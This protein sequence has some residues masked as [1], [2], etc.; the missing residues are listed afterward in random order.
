MQTR[1]VLVIYATSYGQTRRIAQ[2]VADVLTGAGC[3][4][5]VMNAKE[6]AAAG[7]RPEDYEG[8]VVGGSIIARGL[9]PAIAQFVRAHREALDRLPS[10]FFQVSASAGS[11]KAEGRAAAQQLLDR[12][13][14]QSQWHPDLAV[15]VAGA[16]NYTKYNLFLRWFMKRASRLEGGSTDTSRDHEYTDWAQVEDFARQFLAVLERSRQQAPIG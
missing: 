7:V 3:Q 8:V 13:L 11:A 9:Q 5:N 16:I 1:R 4:V 2:R 14:E 12:F 15:S 10:A 6:P